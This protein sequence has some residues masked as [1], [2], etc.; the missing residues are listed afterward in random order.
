MKTFLKFFKYTALVVLVLV[1]GFF[2][3][4]MNWDKIEYQWD[5]RNFEPRVSYK[6]VD[7]TTPL[8]DILFKLGEPDHDGEVV[9]RKVLAWKAEYND[10]YEFVLFTKNNA[11]EFINVFRLPWGRNHPVRTTEGLIDL[12]GEPDIYAETKDFL[13]RRYTYAEHGISFNYK[14]NRLTDVSQGEVEWRSHGSS[15]GLYKVFGKQIC[16][17]ESCPWD[18]EGI[19]PEWEGKSYRDL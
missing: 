6:G 15:T 14:N 19:K 16:P 12:M 13:E 18:E 8:S 9:E 10:S 11:I 4:G 3:I 17:S 5:K 2:V 7:E 1:G